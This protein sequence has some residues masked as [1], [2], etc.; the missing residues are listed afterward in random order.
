MR[1]QITEMTTPCLHQPL[2]AYRVTYADG[3]EYVTNM[4]AN[5]TLE[6]A[7]RYFSGK[8]FELGEYPDDR[9]VKCIN[10]EAL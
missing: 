7:R 4:A 3:T 9:I 10:V 8:F 1:H 2:T 6:E 5:V